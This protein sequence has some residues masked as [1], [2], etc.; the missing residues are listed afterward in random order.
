MHQRWSQITFF[1]W[2]YPPAVVQSLLP[3]GLTVETLDGSAWVGLIPFF[4][5][6]VRSPA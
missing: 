4:M 1:H 6:G 5:E 2:R 3:G